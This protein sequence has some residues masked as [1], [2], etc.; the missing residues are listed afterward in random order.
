M[1]AHYGIAFRHRSLWKN[2][3]FFEIVGEMCPTVA[4]T[5]DTLSVVGNLHI[6][7]YTAL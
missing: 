5:T 4:Q 2:Q 3:I 7:Y 6:G 1:Y